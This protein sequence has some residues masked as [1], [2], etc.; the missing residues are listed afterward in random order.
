MPI[1]LLGDFLLAAAMIFNQA[2]PKV[3]IDSGED[4]KYYQ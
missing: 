4:H 3:N 1:R 2:M